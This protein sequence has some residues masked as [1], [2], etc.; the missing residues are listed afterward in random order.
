MICSI[1]NAE[2]ETHGGLHGHI[3]KK[4]GMAQSD[5]YHTFFPRYDL[6]DKE[7]ICYK[8]YDQYF[9]A[10]FNSRD[11]FLDWFMDNYKDEK[12]KDYCFSLLRERADRK[13]TKRFPSQ[14]ELKSMLLPSILGWERVYSSLPLFASNISQ[15]GFDLG[16][17]YV[18]TPSF[19]ESKPMRIYQDTR[20]QTPLRFG[21][22]VEVMKLPCGDYAP[23]KEY[24]CDLVVERK[25]LSDLVGTLTGGKERFYR[26]VQKA[27]DMGLYLVVVVEEMYSEA[28]N[29][30]SANRYSKKVN[31]AH[32]FYEIRELCNKFDNIQFLFSGTRHRSSD[33]IE[34][35]FR[36]GQA[37][38]TFDLE[39]LKDKKVI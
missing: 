34:K 3:K 1:C 17:D 31:G 2:Y 37:A 23:S 5:Y 35:I 7:L 30:T 22:E 14:V 8:T 11:T 36:M 6:H 19:D 33:L 39:F 16:Y 29:Y 25:S 13:A 38:K 21:C 28:L 4:H 27:K 10:S 15:A 26:E 24:Y 32:I 20:E 18:S 12:V 9:N